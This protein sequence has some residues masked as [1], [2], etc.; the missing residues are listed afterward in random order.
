V[1]GHHLRQAGEVVE[2]AGSEVG[3]HRGVG[4]DLVVVTAGSE[5]AGHRRGAHDGRSATWGGFRLALSAG[6][7]GSGW[8]P[9]DDDTTAHEE[10][11]AALV[12]VFIGAR[13]RGVEW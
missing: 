9:D 7:L 10:T 1:E 13:S 12:G 5:V 3:K 8:I 4:A 6:R 2:G 11:A